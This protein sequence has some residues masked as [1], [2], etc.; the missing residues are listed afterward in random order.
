MYSNRRKANI[1]ALLLIFQYI[2][3]QDEEEVKKFRDKFHDICSGYPQVFHI[4][5]DILDIK[6]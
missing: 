5:Q 4:I 6:F 1:F 3:L 2:D